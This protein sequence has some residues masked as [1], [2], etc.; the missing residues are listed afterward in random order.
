[1][2]ELSQSGIKPSSF[3][4]IPTLMK[5]ATTPITIPAIDKPS[6]RAFVLLTKPMTEKP[7]P[8]GRRINA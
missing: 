3:R 7:I 5:Q 1:M 8:A 4:S 6:V 2:P